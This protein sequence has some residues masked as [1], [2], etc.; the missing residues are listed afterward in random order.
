MTIPFEYRFILS[1]YIN[2]HFLTLKLNLP[3]EPLLI[4]LWFAILSLADDLVPFAWVSL[5][6]AIF[7]NL[8][9]TINEKYMFSKDKRDCDVQYNC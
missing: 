2:I 4:V 8:Y 3:V 5:W 7:S 1:Y 6:S 9:L